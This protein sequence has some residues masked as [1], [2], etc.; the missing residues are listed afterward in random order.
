MAD[1]AAAREQ[2]LTTAWEQV[3]AR[4]GEDEAHQRFLGLA[5][6]M[7]ELRG[8]AQ[9]YR[10]VADRDPARK[11]EAELRLAQLTAR[12][13]SSLDA[14]RRDRRTEQRSR[15]LWLVYG[16]SVAFLMYA[17]FSI[18]RAARD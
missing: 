3:E 13:L 5:Q 10:A 15:A 16:V 18:L 12:A 17:V 8:A 6:A 2:A 4:W 14:A 11:A 1:S 9:R 7:G